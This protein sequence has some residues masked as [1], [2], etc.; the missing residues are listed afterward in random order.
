MLPCSTSERY[1]RAGAER[2][3]CTPCAPRTSA[4]SSSGSSENAESGPPSARRRVKCFSITQAPSATAAIATSMPSV[5][6][7]SPIGQ[8]KSAARSGDPAQV[9]LVRPASGSR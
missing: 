6:S 1:G 2:I 4:A 8:S 5:W 9:R 3:E 7:D